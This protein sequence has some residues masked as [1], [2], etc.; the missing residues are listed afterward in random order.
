MLAIAAHFDYEIW[1]MDVKTAFVN[2]NLTKDICI[3]Q[4]EGLSIWL[5]LTKYVSS[6]NSFMG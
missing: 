2:A 3:I 5:M 6:R 4:P 1:K